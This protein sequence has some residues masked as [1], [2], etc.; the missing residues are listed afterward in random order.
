MR[1]S[2]ALYRVPGSPGSAPAGGSVQL[3]E[4]RGLHERL[5]RVGAVRRVPP[6]GLVDPDGDIA[7]F[8]RAVEHII[9]K[10]RQAVDG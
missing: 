6:G 9:G 4:S 7:T 3:L 5:R 1:G 10:P 2:Y 8:F